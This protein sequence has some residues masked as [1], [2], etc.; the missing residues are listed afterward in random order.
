MLF[1]KHVVIKN[2]IDNIPAEFID[3]HKL[4]DEQQD[5]AHQVVDLANKIKKQTDSI[6]NKSYA[7]KELKEALVLIDYEKLLSDQETID[8]L[9]TDINEMQ[10]K[11]TSIN[12]KNKDA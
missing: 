12:K 3:I 9:N 6:T 2:Q 8:A 5:K 7:V 1:E 4:L 10:Q 11:L